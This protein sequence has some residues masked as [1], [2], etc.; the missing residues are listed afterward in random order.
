MCWDDS[1]HLA[2]VVAAAAAVADLL[3]LGLLHVI[4]PEVDPLTRPV[5]EYALGNF[6]W[7]ASTRTVVEGVGVIAL[8]VSLLLERALTPPVRLVRAAALILLVVG[9]LKLAIPLFPVDPLGTRPTSAGQIHNVL[10]NLTF[11]LYPLAALLLFGAFK[12]MGSRLVPAC[13]VVLALATVGVLI[14][15]AVGVLGLAQR[16]YLVL[17]AI[18]LFLAARAVLRRRSGDSLPHL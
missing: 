9:L 15:N 18:W 16:L 1:V 17:S 10:G 5:S 13:S 2:P 12:R 7:L 3:L 6:G 8:A 14:G 11:F 4:S